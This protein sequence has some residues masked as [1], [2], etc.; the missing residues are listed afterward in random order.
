MMAPAA[1]HDTSELN[2]DTTCWNASSSMFSCGSEL[3][4]NATVRLGENKMSKTDCKAAQEMTEAMGTRIDDLEKN[5][6]E[7]MTKAGIEDKASPNLCG[8]TA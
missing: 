1:T 7:L 5:V 2:T 8:R 3:R 4:N 6:T